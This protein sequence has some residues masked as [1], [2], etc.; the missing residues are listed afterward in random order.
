M[1]AG[2][3]R[4][5]TLCG[6]NC[7]GSKIWNF[8]TKTSL[9]LILKEA[10]AGTAFLYVARKCCPFPRCSGLQPRALCVSAP[11]HSAS[12]GAMAWERPQS[13]ALVSSGSLAPV[14]PDCGF[15]PSSMGCRGGGELG[16][17]VVEV[18][19]AVL[20]LRGSWVSADSPPE[21]LRHVLQGGTLYCTPNSVSA[22]WRSCWCAPSCG[23]CQ[24]Q[25]L[26]PE[27]GPDLAST[28]FRAQLAGL[29][30]RPDGPSR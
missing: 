3:T 27:A 14:H 28:S 4:C 22:T 9:Q 8:P 16:G 30:G 25:Q 20:A 6:V 18:G 29:G 23:Q 24:E 13:P 5:V 11:G 26:L 12:V 17:W 21:A 10:E 7:K 1:C 19:K 2:C 15:D